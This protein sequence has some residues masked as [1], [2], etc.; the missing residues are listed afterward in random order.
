MENK[1]DEKYPFSFLATYSTKKPE[2][3]I[4]HAP[5][6]YALTEYKDE[7]DK[8]LELLSCLN[9]AGD[10]SSLIGEFTSSGE[11]FHP[12]RITSKEAWRLL[13]DIPAIEE[14]GIVCRI[15]EATS[16]CLKHSD[17]D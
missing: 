13:K 1:N 2:G 12:L 16:L 10:V 8:I 11:M 3:K 9:R 6:K 4:K 14:T 15:P 7:R 5:L 17:W